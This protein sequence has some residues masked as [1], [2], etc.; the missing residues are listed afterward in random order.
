MRGIRESTGEVGNRDGE[1][2]W[3]VAMRPGRRRRLDPEGKEALA[4]KLKAFI[5]ARVEHPFLKVKQVYGY[6]K[7]GTLPGSG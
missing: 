5:R 4:E 2:N 6:A 1:V 7:V 3:Q